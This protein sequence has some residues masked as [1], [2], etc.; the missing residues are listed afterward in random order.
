MRA[1]L[2]IIDR[3]VNNSIF[4]LSILHFCALKAGLKYMYKY[5]IRMRLVAMNFMD[6]ALFTFLLLPESM[7]LSA[8]HGDLPVPGPSR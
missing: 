4:S 1:T 7:I 3:C 6:M 8:Q 2:I 5:G